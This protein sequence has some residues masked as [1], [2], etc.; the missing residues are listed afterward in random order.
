[1]E[2][3]G[4]IGVGRMGSAIL[5]RLLQAGAHVT[6]CDLDAGAV[7]R[8]R[9]LG[10]AAAVSPAEVGRAATMIHVI[11]R[12]DADVV[13]CTTGKGGVL[14][15]AQPGT[16]V[17]LH[18]TIRPD[19]TTTVAAAASRQGV[20]IVDAC[21][22]GMPNIARAGDERFLIGAADELVERVTAHL[23]QVGKEVVHAGPVGSA[24]LVKLANNLLFGSQPL[25]LR[26]AVRIAEAGGVPYQRAL[27]IMRQLHTG[28]VIE[29]WESTFTP[30][31]NDFSLH[32][33]NNVFGKD[34][35]LLADLAAAYG[36]D[37]PVTRV[38]ASEG[39]RLLHQD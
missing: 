16:V 17:L 11:V 14:E 36:V 23:L 29:H 13:A 5:E 21:M 6:V 15:G 35:P 25:V 34:L 18:S 32:L 7:E 4:M 19:T 24:N 31:G 28:A 33:G 1:M 38:L 39:E 8:A 26:E 27:E 37:A 22:L 2:P 30:N 9:S 3:T 20:H 12:V 10:A